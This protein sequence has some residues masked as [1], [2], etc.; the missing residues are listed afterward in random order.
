MVLYKGYTK[1]KQAMKRNETNNCPTPSGILIIIG[2]KEN[3]G[4]E[5]EQE[6]S[7]YN[8]VPMEILKTFLDFIKSK[9]PII[10]II[11]TASSEGKESFADYKKVFNELGIKQIGHI[12]HT[13]RKEV[14]EDDIEERVNAAHAFFFSG[15]DQ[16]L[17]TS[18]Y[19]GSRFL[20]QLKE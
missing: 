1:R 14:L 16:L 19:G 7:P 20:T 11:T 2:G 5:P 12:H 3:K 13:T 10:E 17:L 18:L 8:Y 9:E 6:M 15:G 4:N